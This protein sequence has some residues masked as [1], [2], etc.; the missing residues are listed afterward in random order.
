MQGKDIRPGADV[1]A[2][3]LRPGQALED[4]VQQQVQKAL[5]SALPRRPP[6]ASPGEE[7][8]RH[9]RIDHNT[10]VK[11]DGETAM[12]FNISRS[13]LKLSSPFAPRTGNV[14]ISLETGDR[15]YALKGIIR[16]VSARR[17]FSN[18]VDFGVEIIEAPP[19]YYEFVDRLDPPR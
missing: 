17:S 16:W 7:K 14:A 10:M 19:E 12:L 9:P 3:R 13:G 11:V 2:L 8:R 5:Q 18:L 1:P 6:L 15:T 4:M